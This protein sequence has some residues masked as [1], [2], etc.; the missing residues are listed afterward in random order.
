MKKFKTK[1]L[2]VYLFPALM[3][4]SVAAVLIFSAIRAV[5][6]GAKAFVVGIL[7]SVWGITYF[8]SSLILSRIITRKNSTTFMLFSCVSFAFIGLFFGFF[9]SLYSLFLLLIIGGLFASFFFVG[10]QLFMEHSSGTISSRASALYT[11]SWSAGMAF[12]SLAEGFLMNRGFLWARLPILLPAVVVIFGILVSQKL[13]NSKD[14]YE[15]AQ[16]NN[17]PDTFLKVYAKIAWI[18]IFTVTFVTVGIRYLLPKMTISFFNFSHTSAASAVFLFFV[19]QAM[20]GYV[21]CF[22]RFLSYNLKAHNLLKLLAAMGLI[23]P[24]LFPYD[25]SVFLSVCCLGIY[26]GHA[27]WASVFYA[28]NDRRRAG[29]NVGINES[30]VGISSVLGPFLF[31][32]MLNSGVL[33]FL[34]FP[35]LVFILSS[36]FQ[37]GVVKK[38]RVIP[39]VP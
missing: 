13:N 33:Q 9:K 32:I 2:W 27:F 26:S 10:F 25:F 6:F 36:F 3:D 21:S 38:N 8:V 24:V 39:E 28:I 19:L 34:I 35:W 30:L 5:E 1:R 16:E 20:S 14:L 18:E 23:V 31:G 17:I 37:Y 29:F 11:L 12:G 15:K 4:L 7:G 22:F